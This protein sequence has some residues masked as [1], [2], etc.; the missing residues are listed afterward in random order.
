MEHVNSEL[1][2]NPAML[3]MSEDNVNKIDELIYNTFIKVA[4]RVLKAKK[5]TKFS[6]NKK[7]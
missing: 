1:L 4:K 6:K 2:N 5:P 3:A 7:K